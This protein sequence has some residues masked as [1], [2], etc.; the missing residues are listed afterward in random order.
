M[1]TVASSGRPQRRY[2][3]PLTDTAVRNLKPSGKALKLADAG[4][5]YLYR[6]HSTA[7]YDAPTSLVAI[8]IRRASSTTER[9]PRLLLSN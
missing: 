3:I 2:P 1:C 6:G 5:L 8:Q 7:V 4:G 9:K